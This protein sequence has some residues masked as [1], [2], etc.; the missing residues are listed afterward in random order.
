MTVSCYRLQVKD[1]AYQLRADNWKLTCQ[2]E[3]R[4]QQ[5]RQPRWPKGVHMFW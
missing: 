2:D 5:T 4:R 3:E 1:H